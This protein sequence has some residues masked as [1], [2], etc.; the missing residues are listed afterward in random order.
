MSSF[1]ARRL[2]QFIPT[3]LGVMLLVFLLFNWV[4]GVPAYVLAGKI[5]SPDDRGD[6]AATLQAIDDIIGR[7]SAAFI[8]SVVG[9]GADDAPPGPE[10]QVVMAEDRER[11]RAVLDLLPE[12]E[13]ALIDGY[14]FH[15][16][17]LEELKAS[18]RSPE[19]PLGPANEPP[20]HY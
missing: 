8:I 18:I 7:T 6:I 19:V 10:A 12:R 9:Q 17:T 16:R 11:V 15:E 5:A 3:L 13:R 14:Y 1:L 4:G 20:P 2:W